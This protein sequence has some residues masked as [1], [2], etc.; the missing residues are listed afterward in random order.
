MRE[1]TLVLG[2]VG[3]QAT[4]GTAHHSVLAHKYNTLSPQRG[5]NLVHLLGR[6][7]ER[8]WLVSFLPHHR[9]NRNHRRLLAETHIVDSNDENALVL[10]EKTFELFEI[11]GFVS[12]GPHIFLYYEERIFKVQDCRWWYL[13]GWKSRRTV[14]QGGKFQIFFFHQRVVDCGG[15][16][17]A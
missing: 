12:L 10:L 2:K 8:R 14:G 15:P 1:Q 13:R 9:H 5:A 4:N 7:L 16:K 17:S 6:Y 11:L 3:D